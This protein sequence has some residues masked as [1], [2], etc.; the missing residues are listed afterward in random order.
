MTFVISPMVHLLYKYHYVN[1]LLTNLREHVLPQGSKH[2]NKLNIRSFHIHD[3]IFNKIIGNNIFF[4]NFHVKAFK[5]N[6]I[7]SNMV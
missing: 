1:Q 5:I 3:D 7:E 4:S 6:F 2:I